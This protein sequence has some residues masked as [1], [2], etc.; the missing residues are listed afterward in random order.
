[1][2]DGMHVERLSRWPRDGAARDL[3]RGEWQRLLAR[4]DGCSIFQHHDW[5]DAWWQAF[6][7]GCELMV[8][9]V[10]DGHGELQA[11]A[12]LMILPERRFGIA[13]RRLLMIGTANAA[14]DY[15]DLIVA[16]GNAR[17]RAAI[18]EWLVAQ[19]HAWTSIELFNVPEHSP[20]LSLLDGATARRRPLVQFA[21][22]APARQ[23]GDAVADRQV[24]AKKSLRRHLNGFRRDG[25]LD[26]IRLRTRSEVEERL[27]AFFDQHLQR[28][29]GTR[30]PSLFADP[31]QRCFYRALV[32]RLDP[33]G[34]LNFSVVL[35]DGKP[36]AFHFGF[37]FDG[38]FVWYK[39][40]FDPALHKRSPGE[41][42]IRCLLE[43][44]IARGLREFDFT[45]G[46][47]DFKYRFATVVRRVFRLWLYRHAWDYLP[48]LARD[49]AKRV[50]VRM[51][52]A[53]VRQSPGAVP[54]AE[55]RPRARS[56]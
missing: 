19:R 40:T 51:R 1:L 42:L 39:P 52:G 14:A 29:A 24:L 15:A 11:I 50:L 27:E 2:N 16:R 9:L 10:R 32:E 34:P 21:A 31:A 12:P 20:T 54:S 30:T 28:W 5:L 47:E 8:L 49:T 6:G 35:F 44:A 4:S 55:E 3:L 17:A 7:E 56:A 43:D 13:R 33:E 23:L 41:V 53:G 18:R 25:T 46:S 22:E 38:V 36:I 37:E 48:A 45:V 26:F